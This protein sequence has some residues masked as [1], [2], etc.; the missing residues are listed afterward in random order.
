MRRTGPP[1]AG[2]LTAPHRF[3][4]DP[5]NRL[6]CG[7]VT[8][9]DEMRDVGE[10]LL[11]HERSLAIELDDAIAEQMRSTYLGK[12]E[13]Q[14]LAQAVGHRLRGL[15]MLEATEMVL[16]S[17]ERGAELRD[18]FANA[19]WVETVDAWLEGDQNAVLDRW[20]VA[21]ARFPHLTRK[22][23]AEGEQW[24]GHLEHEL[25]QALG[26]LLRTQIAEREHWEARQGEW[27]CNFGSGAADFAVIAHA[28]GLPIARSTPVL[29]A[30]MYSVFAGIARGAQTT[31][32]NQFAHVAAF[33]G[34][35]EIV[36]LV[37]AYRGRR[38][39]M[40]STEIPAHFLIRDYNFAPTG[41]LLS[42]ERGDPKGA[43][44]AYAEALEIMQRDEYLKDIPAEARRVWKPSV[45]WAGAVCAVFQDDAVEFAAAMKEVV[46]N[47]LKEARKLM[48][49][50]FEGDQFLAMRNAALVRVSGRSGLEL[51]EK[52]EYLTL[53][54]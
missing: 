16:E 54:G 13:G 2:G 36:R 41:A 39:K 1:S 31:T 33:L 34:D 19:P 29:E 53:D 24:L 10:D 28:L 49:K 4:P 15:D 35:A 11:E 50:G 3:F 9:K 47:E 37:S 38:Y 5:R 25:S 32:A 44:E 20:A 26:R 18:E 22:M 40:L 8:L 46:A 27:L 43:R 30:G 14:A 52:S 23:K 42:I 51:A 17:L 21:L 6:R 45:P 12:R 7:T 48:K